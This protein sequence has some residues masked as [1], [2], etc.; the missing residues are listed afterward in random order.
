MSDH[1]TRDF[2]AAVAQLS[3]EDFQEIVALAK[4]DLREARERLDRLG[5]SLSMWDWEHKA[6]F[7]KGKRECAIAAIAY[8]YVAIDYKNVGKIIRIFLMYEEHV[9]DKRLI[10]SII[11]HNLLEISS[12]L[13]DII[14]NSADKN[15]LPP[16]NFSIESHDIFFHYGFSIK[17]NWIVDTLASYDVRRLASVRRWCSDKKCAQE[18]R[19]SFDQE[20]ARVWPIIRHQVYDLWLAA[21]EPSGR[22]DPREFIEDF[23]L[24]A[25]ESKWLEELLRDLQRQKLERDGWGYHQLVKSF[26]HFKLSAVLILAIGWDRGVFFGGGGGQEAGRWR[27]GHGG[28]GGGLAKA[29]VWKRSSQEEKIR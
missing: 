2:G 12:A 27:G 10:V 14:I 26:E 4:T 13:H 6:E 29:R 8:P 1:S 9:I 15:L 17:L 22:T 21:C 18:F 3:E 20:V 25:R 5:V 19:T 7:G 11:I 23:P 24:M 16:Y 28:R